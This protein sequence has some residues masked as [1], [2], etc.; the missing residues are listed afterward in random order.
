MKCIPAEGVDFETGHFCNFL[1]S[2]TL[3]LDWSYG[4]PWCIQILE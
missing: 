3:T 2:V 4:I 1:N